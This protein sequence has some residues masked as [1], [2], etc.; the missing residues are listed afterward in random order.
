MGNYRFTDTDKLKKTLDHKAVADFLKNDL[1]IQT[2]IVAILTVIMLPA[3]IAGWE[4]R[5]LAICVAAALLL[6]FAGYLVYCYVKIAKRKYVVE[7][8][9][10]CD[11]RRDVILRGR[12]GKIQVVD[13][14]CF[15]KNGEYML[16]SKKLL[17][18][19]EIGD[20]F[21]ILRF[22]KKFNFSRRA[23]LPLNVYRTKMYEWRI[24]NK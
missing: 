21:Y 1:K 19:T 2:A 13:L 22:D 23:Q 3:A 20:T 7:V 5:K 12:R 14:L 6:A 24:D 4:T 8:D 15:Q 18:Y 16:H 9:T 10:L 11:I 17:D